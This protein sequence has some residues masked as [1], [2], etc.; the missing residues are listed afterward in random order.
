MGDDEIVPPCAAQVG[1]AVAVSREGKI[2]CI[3]PVLENAV[4]V[5]IAKLITP[6]LP[7]SVIELLTV[8]VRDRI[9][10]VTV[11]EALRKL[12]FAR[13]TVTAIGSLDSIEGGIVIAVMAKE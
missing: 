10:A 12:K 6:F 11:N 3:F 8:K 13:L 5:V 4:S 7:I 2:I 1:L 9:T